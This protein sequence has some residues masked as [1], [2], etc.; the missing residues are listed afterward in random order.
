MRKM[1]LSTTRPSTWQKILR[2][3]W[4]DV[5]HASLEVLSLPFTYTFFTWTVSKTTLVSFH[6]FPIVYPGQEKFLAICKTLKFCNKILKFLHLTQVNFTSTYILIFGSNEKYFDIFISLLRNSLHTKFPAG[7]SNA[8]RNSNVATNNDDYKECMVLWVDQSSM[9]AS[10]C[11]CC[12]WGG[13]ESSTWAESMMDLS[14]YLHIIFIY[15]TLYM[16][17]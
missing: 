14:P 15:S 10:S 4:K 16:E 17:R 1:D 6:N 11:I 12:V 5:F 7:A 8:W 2:L 3:K 9:G 13:G